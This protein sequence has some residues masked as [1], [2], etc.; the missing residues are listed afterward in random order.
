MP[1]A[2]VSQTVQASR[3]VCSLVLSYAY[4]TTSPY[5]LTSLAN[6][7]TRTPS[8]Y[9]IAVDLFTNMRTMSGPMPLP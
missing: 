6:S 1:P 5:I 3:A 2:C 7:F 4:A 9:S 8:F